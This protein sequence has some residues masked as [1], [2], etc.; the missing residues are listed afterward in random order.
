MYICV[1]RY[2]L[3]MA[4]EKLAIYIYIISIIYMYII[5]IIYIIYIMENKMKAKEV[6]GLAQ[7]IHLLFVLVM[8]F[9]S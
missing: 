5:Y 4:I 1:Y 6:R 7:S 8:T 2:G 9:F 3:N